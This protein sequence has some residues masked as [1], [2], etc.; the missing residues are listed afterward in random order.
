MK[1]TMITMKIMIEAKSATIYYNLL[2]S[3]SSKLSP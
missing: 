3:K 2:Q 1:M